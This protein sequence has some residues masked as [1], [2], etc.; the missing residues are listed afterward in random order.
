MIDENTGSG[1]IVFGEEG[2]RVEAKTML[3]WFRVFGL[4]ASRPGGSDAFGQP[5]AARPAAM[6]R[7]SLAAI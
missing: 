6:E 3:S 7:S 4:A 2:T 1:V 5:A